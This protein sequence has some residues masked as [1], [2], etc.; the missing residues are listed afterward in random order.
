[1]EATCSADT[2]LAPTIRVH[3]PLSSL[4][5][6][7]ACRHQ[8]NVEVRVTVPLAVRGLLAPPAARAPPVLHHVHR[9]LHWGLRRCCALHSTHVVTCIRSSRRQKCWRVLLWRCPR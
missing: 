4:L 9:R 6:H 5:M 8:D 2:C 7:P 3:H 1:M